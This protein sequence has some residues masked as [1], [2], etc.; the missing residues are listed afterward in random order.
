[1]N[2]EITYIE[3]EIFVKM[4]KKQKSEIPSVSFYNNHE[5]NRL[6][7]VPTNRKSSGYFLG[8]F[9]VYTEGKGWWR[10]MTYDCWKIV[11]DIENPAS[12]RFQILQGDF[13]NGGVQ[14]F[15]FGSEH[16]KAYISYGGE[17]IIKNN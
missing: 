16:H 11:T 5:I 4:T 8:D 7:I 9:F 1:M 2:K 13:E 15:G 17:I 10:P 12:F 14:I 3:N 6:V